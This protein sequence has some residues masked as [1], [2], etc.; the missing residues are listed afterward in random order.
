MIDIKWLEGEGLQ[1]YRADLQSRKGDVALIDQLLEKNEQR[2]RRISEIEAL[3][4]KQNKLSE[5]VGKLKRSGGNADELMREIPQ[6]KTDI[7]RLEEGLKEA[8]NSVDQ[9]LS[10]LPN[11]LHASVPVGAGSEGN[12]V[13]HT[14]GEAPRFGFKPKEHWELGEREGRLDFERA[15]KVAGARFAILRG[16]LAQLERALINFMLDLHTRNHGYEET[17]PPFIVNSKSLFG[18]GQFP[19]FVDDVFHLVGTDYHLIPTA[20]VPVTNYFGDEYLSEEQLPLAL[21]AYT[22]CFRSEAGSHGKD[23]KGLIRQHQFNKVE[24]VRFSHPGDSYD[25]LEK[26][27]SHAEEVLK[28]LGLHFR[29][30]ALCSGDIGFGSSKTYDLEVWLPGQNAFREISSCS[31][32]EDFQARRANI[33]FRPKGGGKPQFVH[34]LNGSGLAVGRCLIAVLENNQRE[35]GSIAIPEAL[36]PYMA[37]KSEL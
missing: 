22:P 5:E 13:I 32:Y 19:K 11:R 31:N 37:G 8:Q 1:Q 21:T 12:K 29:R 20:E 34:T 17:V 28:R 33:R 26:L 14:W 27:T 18:T 23:V 35:D 6:L 9:C 36:R 25:Q 15:A 7:A 3:K 30:M 16:D 10:I 24:L 2:R 4:S